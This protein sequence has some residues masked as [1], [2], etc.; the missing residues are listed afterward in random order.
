[1]G[2]PVVGAI[3]PRVLGLRI[4]EARKARGLTQMEAATVLGIS[5]PTY[6]AIEKGHRAVLPDELIRLAELY[7]RSAHE[8]LRRREPVRDFVT[9][10][11]A[12]ASRG[13]VVTTEL[14]AAVALLQR[15]CDDYVDLEVK[16]RAPLPRNYPP[17]YA[18]E[19]RDAQE[20]VEE[21]AAQERNRLGLGDGP[22][23][24]LRALLEVDVGLRIFYLDLPSR[25]AGLFVFTE[26]L[27]G[28]IAIQRK[29]PPGRRLWSLAH[30]YAHFL[31]HRYEAEVTVLRTDTRS[32]AKER[33][34]DA[35]AGSFLM[36][37]LGLRRR[38]YDLQRQSGQITP[39]SLLTLA[40]LYGVSVEAML[41]RLEN[42]RLIPVGTWERLKERGFSI[43][44]VRALLGLSDGPDEPW[45]PPRYEGLAV[46]A[47]EDG[48]LSEGE[49]MHVL[50]TDREQARRTVRRLTTRSAVSDEGDAGDL[51][52]DLAEPLGGSR[53]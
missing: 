19:G 17:S 53:G 11:R 22:V 20:V 30:E 35:F 18:V 41:V 42:L 37:T 27:G 2:S 23:P 51:H 44:G 32:V 21:V 28:C 13:A 38:F 34:A 10:F 26:E 47:F 15:L 48:L 16:C 52:L 25:V 24:N 6:I 7:S 45:L 29:H 14:D 39:A 50:H 36:P 5:R 43:K 3:D 9:H 33:F 31:I 46:Q 40:D 1:M 4:Q 49:L 12:A 8:L